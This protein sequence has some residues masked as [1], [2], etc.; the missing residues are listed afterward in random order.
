MY[1][2]AIKSTMYLVDS[3]TVRYMVLSACGQDKPAD[4]SYGDFAFPGGG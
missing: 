2:K 4:D 1:E 3:L